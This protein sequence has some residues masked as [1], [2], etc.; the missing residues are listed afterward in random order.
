MSSGW[1]EALRFRLDTG[2]HNS[3]GCRRVR[4]NHRGAAGAESLA[5]EEIAWRWGFIGTEHLLK[6]KQ[7]LAKSGY[8]EYLMRL[9]KEQ[10]SL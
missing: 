6:L 9:V 5:S 10:G 8:G 3:A 2:T 4:A 7:P 1:A